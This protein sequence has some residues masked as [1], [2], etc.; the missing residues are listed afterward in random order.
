M[1]RQD[2]VRAAILTAAVFIAHEFTG[3]TGIEKLAASSGGYWWIVLFLTYMAFM[4]LA[5]KV[6]WKS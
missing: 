2:I 1:M 6:K 5:D 3:V 4:Y